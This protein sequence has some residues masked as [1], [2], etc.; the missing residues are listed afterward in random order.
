MGTRDQAN[1]FPGNVCQCLT[2]PT[3]K[4]FSLISNLTP[5]SAGLEPFP[6]SCH[7]S[8]ISLRISEPDPLGLFIKPHQSKPPKEFLQQEQAHG[9]SGAGWTLLHSRHGNK[10]KNIKGR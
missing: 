4:D 8:H 2:S 1:S 7:S 10:G 3:V 6:R 9:N 5:P